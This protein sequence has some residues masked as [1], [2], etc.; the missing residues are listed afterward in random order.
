[1]HSTNK[2]F[3]KKKFRLDRIKTRDRKSELPLLETILEMAVE[4]E[5]YNFA[6]CIH[7]RME[8]IRNNESEPRS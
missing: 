2:L 8:S 6:H 3:Y 4:A 5:N 7:I 1:M